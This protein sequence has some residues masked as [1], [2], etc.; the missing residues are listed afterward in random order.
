MVNL[1]KCTYSG[2]EM[3]SDAF[4]NKPA[5]NGVALAFKSQKTVLK[6]LQ[7]DIGDSNE[8]KDELVNDIVH[9][10]RW[11]PL[12]MKK[13]EFGVYIKPYLK[14]LCEKV[15]ARTK[16]EAQVKEFQKNSTDL[17]RFV[18]EKFDDFEFHINEN[19]DMDGAIAM[20]YWEDEK[21]DKGPTFLLILEGLEK[22]KI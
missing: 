19:N 10:F 17:V 3:I 9:S 7:F 8:V 18:L 2:C 15:R 14:K 1:Y 6:A 16:D 12:Q 4:P 5:F 20:G 22:T 11:N 13:N 21:N